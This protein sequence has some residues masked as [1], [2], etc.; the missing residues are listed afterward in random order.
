MSLELTNGGRCMSGPDAVAFLEMLPDSIPDEIKNDEFCNEYEWMLNRVR[1][2]VRWSVPLAPKVTKAVSR[3]Y[4][5]FYSC[6]HCG[7]SVRSDI[8]K[9]CPQCGRAI[10]WKAVFARR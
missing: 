4:G 1:A 7:F 10:D 5:D 9:H 8:Y 2:E 3:G 6:G